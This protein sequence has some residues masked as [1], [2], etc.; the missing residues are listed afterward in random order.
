MRCPNCGILIERNNQ[1]LRF[2]WGMLMDAILYYSPE[3]ITLASASIK[4][5]SKTKL[6]EV[7]KVC[8]CLDERPDLWEK[9]KVVIL[10][11]KA[12]MTDRP[13]ST[14]LD[15]LSKK[16]FDEYLTYIK[17]VWCPKYTGFGFETLEEKYKGII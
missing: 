6:H 16:T 9:G 13:F 14:A 1:S 5:D 12:V 8:F 10:D 17:D 4:I 15:S 2:Y 3:S 7:M 11:G